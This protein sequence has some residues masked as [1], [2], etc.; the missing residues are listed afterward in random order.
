MIE[1]DKRTNSYLSSFEIFHY[2]LDHIEGP[3]IFTIVKK[4]I[5]SFDPYVVHPDSYDEYDG[6]SR[7][8]SEKIR[9]GMS[10]EEIA[11]IMIE[12]F[13]WSFSADFTMEDFFP[14]AKTVYNLLEDSSYQGKTNEED[15]KKDYVYVKLYLA[16]V[17][18]VKVPMKG[19]GEEEAIEIVFNKIDSEKKLESPLSSFSIS[20]GWGIREV[21]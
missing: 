10:I 16:K 9:R 14:T 11:Q 1:I 15:T 20:L 5:D 18:P 4:A 19:F 6:E 7:R 3:L 21:E 17:I 13:N 8:I 12:E 2:E